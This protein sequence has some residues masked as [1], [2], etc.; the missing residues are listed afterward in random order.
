[1]SSL[2]WLLGLSGIPYEYNVERNPTSL[3]Y[4][5]LLKKVCPSTEYLFRKVL[6]H[7][8]VLAGATGWWREQGRRIAVDVCLWWHVDD[9]DRIV[10]TILKCAAIPKTPAS[11]GVGVLFGFRDELWDA[12]VCVSDF[13]KSRQIVIALVR[14]IKRVKCLLHS[15]EWHNTWTIAANG[16]HVKLVI[17]LTGAAVTSEWRRLA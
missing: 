13:M 4:R 6:C 2:W 7:T 14:S 10:E 1:M 8:V 16:T 17:L 15:G 3:A 5:P 11:V 12:L 9:P